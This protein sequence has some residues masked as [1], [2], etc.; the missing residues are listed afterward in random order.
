MGKGLVELTMNPGNRENRK[1]AILLLEEAVHLLRETP[2]F[3]L[4]VYAIGTLPFVLALFYFWA[5]MSRSAD[6][7][8]YHA[9]ASLGLVM[10]YIWMKCWHAVFAAR[11]RMKLNGEPPP[12]WSYRRILSMVTAQTIIHATAFFVLPLAAVVVLPFGWCYAFYH[13]VTA[14]A[15]NGSYDVRDLS[16]RAWYQAW[17]WPRQNHFL[18]AIFFIFGIVVF[19]NVASAIYILPHLVKK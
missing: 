19:L 1:S 4:S 10:L 8:N 16:K 15:A 17:L 9:V 2:L 11:I 5:D 18:L 13:N 7:R 3:L 14:E 12:Q 6:A